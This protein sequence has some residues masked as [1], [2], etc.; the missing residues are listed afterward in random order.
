MYSTRRTMRGWGA[1]AEQA[2]YTRGCGR[3]GVLTHCH[4]TDNLG[5]VDRT[6]YHGHGIC[7]LALKHTARPQV[8]R[9]SPTSNA[10]RLSPARVDK[11]AMPQDSRTPRKRRVERGERHKVATVAHHMPTSTR[12]DNGVAQ[13]ARDV[14]M[15]RLRHAAL[16]V[17]VLRRTKAHE[18]VLVGE[19]GEHTNVRA[20][21]RLD[22]NRHGAGECLLS[23]YDAWLEVQPA[24][25]VR[26]RF[27]W[28]AR[29]GALYTDQ[30]CASGM[31]A[32]CTRCTRVTQMSRGFIFR[33]IVQYSLTIFSKLPD[34]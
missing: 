18:A 21:F 2:G 23:L 31:R 22:T 9:Q 19:K 12:G 29:L 3:D 16:P 26:F 28:L 25:L 6:V 14:G 7:K 34:I 5:P 11:V 33:S 1:E 17:E 30:L 15:S 10:R 20:S 13:T 4:P 8:E 27:V 32:R 24:C